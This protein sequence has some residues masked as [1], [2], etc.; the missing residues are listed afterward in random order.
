M[1][2]EER[3]RLDTPSI[4]I[5]TGNH[6][7][8]LGISDFVELTIKAARKV[9]VKVAESRVVHGDLILFIDE[10]SSY[11][12]LKSLVRDKQKH[13]RAYVLLCTEFETHSQGIPSF[14]EFGKGNSLVSFVIGVLAT[15]LFYTPKMLRKSRILMSVLT[16]FAMPL[17]IF[18]IIFKWSTHNGFINLLKSIQRSVYMRSRRKGHEIFK[19]HC[20][21]IIK[22]HP[23]VNRDKNQPILY[24]VLDGVLN[25]ASK[26][27]RVSGTET[28]YRLDKSLE[29]VKKLEERS[30]DYKLD[31]SGR[32]RFD[33]ETAKDRWAFSYQPT[34]SID[35]NMANP[36]K[37]WRDIQFHH[38]LP[39]VDR[40][41]D[42]HPI[43]HVAILSTSFFNSAY[44]HDLIDA[45]IIKYNKL[46]ICANTDLFRQMIA[47]V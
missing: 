8:T 29:F 32:I 3:L 31:F 25:F 39:I 46:A 17:L 19:N 41:F 42:Q 2:K 6:L 24:P 5:Y 28:S 12:E 22:I 4:T 45:E 15:L 27:I 34:Q 20:D 37:I 30:L 36:V 40:K 21:M 16:L 13:K 18:P 33:T 9:S 7:S 1:S 11:F 43:E 38:A 23:L 47:L 35:W 14:N 10:F 44:S 26:K